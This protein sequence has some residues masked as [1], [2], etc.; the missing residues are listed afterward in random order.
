MHVIDPNNFAAEL[1]VFSFTLI[2]DD[3]VSGDIYKNFV[4][5]GAVPIGLRDWET[6]R[7]VQG[8]PGGYEMDRA[9]NP[10]ELD[11]FRAVSLDKGCFLGQESISRVY[12]REAVRKRLWGIELPRS[13]PSVAADAEV[14]CDGANVGFV[15][16]ASVADPF[17]ERRLALAILK[18]KVDKVAVDWQGKHVEIDGHQGVAT[19]LSYMLF[20]FP[21]GK[22]APPSTATRNGMD[23]EDRQQ[24]KEAKLKAMQ[25]RLA[26]YMKQQSDS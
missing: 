20:D 17:S 25:E 13:S 2:V 22:G 21:E 8:R 15:T 18:S 11:L 19:A 24:D 5:A 16:S 9:S 14:L 6:L 7:V 4:D 1:L 23:V 10:F 3:A 12:T 26:A